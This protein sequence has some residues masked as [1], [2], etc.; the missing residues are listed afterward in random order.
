MKILWIPHVAWRIPQRAHL[1]CRGLAGQHEVHVTDWDAD[2]T[3]PSDYLS[4]RYLRNF[5]YRRST[6]GSIVVHGIPRFS[7]AL[8]LTPLRRLNSFLFARFVQHIISRYEIDVVVGTFICPA[9][10][11]PRLLFDLFDDNTGYWRAYGLHRSYADEIEATE[12]A[13]LQ[14]AD[15]VIAASHVLAGRAIEAGACGSVSWIPNGVE[16]SEYDGADGSRWSAR[17]GLAGRLVAVIGNHDKPAEMA[18]LLAIAGLLARDNFH[19]VVAGRG[20]ALPA[21]QKNASLLGLSNIHFVGPLERRAMPEFLAAMHLGL[22][23]YLRTPGADAGSPMRLLQYAAAGLPTV[24][25]DLE[26]TRRMGFENVVLVKDDAQAAVDGLL[27]AA[28]M[29]RRRPPQILE[30]DL[31]KLIGSL[32]DIMAGRK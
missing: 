25:T 4:R 10:Q 23:P 3:R 19:F 17:L 2:F 15:A 20:L 21:A 27:K 32:E 24:C 29:P 6:D 18:K 7:P 8:F 28:H 1:F 16:L 22:C 26:E 31:P 9:P 11:A 14:K 5:T 30:Y 12:R 13:Y